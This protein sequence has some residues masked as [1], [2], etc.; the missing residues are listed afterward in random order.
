MGKLVK[1]AGTGGVIG[2]GQCCV[3]RGRDTQGRDGYVRITAYKVLSMPYRLLLR[4]LQAYMLFTW[5]GWECGLQ[6]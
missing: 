6:V 4:L 2:W 1:V 5:V 3:G